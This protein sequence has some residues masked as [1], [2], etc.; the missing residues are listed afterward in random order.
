MYSNTSGTNGTITLSETA[1]N[2]SYLEIYFV[3]D[4]NVLTMTKVYNPN[5]KGASLSATNYYQ[6]YIYVKGTYLAISGTS[7]TWSYTGWLY[8]TGGSSLTVN[9]NFSMSVTQ[10]IGYR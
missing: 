8:G 5:G 2:F 10:I 6:G 4:S 9:S 3:P 7:L 1:A